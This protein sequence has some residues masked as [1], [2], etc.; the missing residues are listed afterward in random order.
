MSDATPLVTACG[1]TAGDHCTDARSRTDKVL[2][3]HDELREQM[4][5]LAAGINR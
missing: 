3:R 1:E 2:K 5:D 4:S